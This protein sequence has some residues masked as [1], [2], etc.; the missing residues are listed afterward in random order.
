M[1]ING[2]LAS[3]FFASRLDS[4]VPDVVVD[5]VDVSM[6]VI[7]LLFALLT[8]SVYDV[9]PSAAVDASLRRPALAFRSSVVILW[10]TEC[11]TSHR[12]MSTR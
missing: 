8:S 1:A 6:L 7:L 2:L 9:H 12:L 10:L 5:V 4:V 11:A 3:A